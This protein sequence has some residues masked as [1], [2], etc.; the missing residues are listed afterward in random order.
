MLREQ[1]YV[2]QEVIMGIRPEDIHD[3]PVFINAAQ[4][5]VVNAKK[6]RYPSC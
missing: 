2:G 4:G 3:E 6:L 1:G 5:S